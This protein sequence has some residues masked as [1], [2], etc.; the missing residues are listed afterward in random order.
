[1]RGDFER[2]IRDLAASDAAFR[3]HLLADPLAA[4]AEHGLWLDG[5]AV[6]VVEEAADEVVIVLP[7]SQ[8][9]VLTEAELAHADGGG[10]QSVQICVTDAVYCGQTGPARCPH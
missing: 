8:A 1:M 9:D 6:R 5:F 3:A 4:L 7:A 10:V 2:E